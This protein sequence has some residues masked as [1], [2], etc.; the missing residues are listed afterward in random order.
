M[1]R[2]LGGNK[3]LPSFESAPKTGPLPKVE[4]YYE[5]KAVLLVADKDFL[6]QKYVVERLSIHQI[7][8]EV[9][10][11]RSTV[12]EY[13]AEF[14]IETRVTPLS[15]QCRGQVPY[16]SRM[17]N[18][19]L[20]PHLGEQAVIRELLEKRAAGESYGDLVSW[21]NER[22]TKTKNGGKWDRPTV[23]KI[24]QRALQAK[25]IRD[26]LNT[27]AVEPTLSAPVYAER[28]SG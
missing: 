9:G 4:I 28:G 15:D 22:G 6:Y 11:A 8:A 25:S 16:G 19:H 18:G 1:L 2:I 12:G 14:G 23:Y 26:E 21:L 24:I 27:G 10:C 17:A 7:A 20:V 13:L 3:W 5:F